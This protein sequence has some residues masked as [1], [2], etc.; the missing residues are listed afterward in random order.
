MSTTAYKKK[1]IKAVLK[2]IDNC[3]D[4]IYENELTTDDYSEEEL[5]ELY[6]DYFVLPQNKK[7]PKE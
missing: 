5:M 3:H 6:V 4:D 1:I 7:N 2:A